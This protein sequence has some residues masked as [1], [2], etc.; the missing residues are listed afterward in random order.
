MEKFKLFITEQ[1]KNAPER[2]IKDR[3][4][5]ETFRRAPRTSDKTT[6]EM[7]EKGYADIAIIRNAVAYE[8]LGQKDDSKSPAEI[9]SF[10][11]LN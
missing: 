4:G 3:L 8:A 10:G 6:W 1:L 5:E 11:L 9:N 7:L 2:E